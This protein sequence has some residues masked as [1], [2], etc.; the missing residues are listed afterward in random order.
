MAQSLLTATK[1]LRKA[2]QILHNNYG[3]TKGVDRQ[4]SDEFAKSGA[5][6]G[7]P[8]HVRLPNRYTVR[9][10][11]TMSTQEVV[12][13]SVE[14][15]CGSII[16]VDLNFSSVELALELDDFADRILKPAMSRLASEI[17]F[18]GL[19][20]YKNIYNQVG[21]AGTT[22]A[23]A[24]TVLQAGQKLNEFAAPHGDERS[25]VYNPAAEAKT[26]DAL[27][28]LFQ[29]STAI[30]DQYK[31]G[32]MGRALGFK[33]MMDQNVNSHTTGAFT[34]DCIPVTNGIGVEGAATLVTDGWK[35][36]TVVLKEGD[37]FTIA[38][39]NAV[40]PETGQD[41]GVLQQFR[42]TADETSD[43]SGDLTIAISPKLI[44]T[45]AKKTITALPADGITINVTSMGTESTAYPINMAYHKNAFTLVTADLPKP[46]GVDFAAREV[47]DGI[48]MLI[49]RQYTINDQSFPCRIDILHDWTTLRPELACRIIG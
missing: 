29:Q 26:V 5:K 49:V 46:D 32:M 6:D 37:L 35:I 18:L 4:Y 9:T 28:G 44:T 22:P 21:T 30:A 15:A 13:E 31:S 48:S 47:Y 1:V 25:L 24:L 19:G 14:I 45:G 27:K 34:T 20:Q 42:V 2:L 41:N 23:S 11:N 10:G 39:V 43:G 3:F 16:G 8:I 17:D 38:G 40:S 7:S 33:F 36:N 12:E